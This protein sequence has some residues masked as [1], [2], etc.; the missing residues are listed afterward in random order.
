[1]KMKIK[2]L[3]KVIKN[4]AKEWV[5]DDP[6][7][8]SAIIAYYAI[9]SLPALLVLV[10]NIAGFFLEKDAISGEI[11]RQ[12][13]A[14]MGQDTG[15]QIQKIVA[16]A[17]KVKA[18]LL[19]G[20]IAIVVLISGATGV[21]VQLQ[22][23]LNQIWGVKQKASAGIM[24]T[25][26]NRVFSFGLILAIGFLLLVS[27][28]I[29]SVLA[30]VSHWLESALSDAVAYLI[31]VVDFVV[32]LGITS[33]LFALMFKYLPDVK[34][35]WKNVWIGGILTGFLFI[36]GKYGLSLYFGKA[37]PASV[38]GA[39]GSII[40]VLLWVSYSSMIVFFG[41]EFTQ[42]YAVATKA[43]IKVSENAEITDPHA[44]LQLSTPE[45]HK[46]K[47]R[48]RF[49]SI[50]SEKDLEAEI[51]RSELHLVVKKVQIKDKISSLTHIFRKKDRG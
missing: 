5:E 6:F 26:K 33:V 19:P 27:L 34:I 38:Y 29:S 37:N 24:V 7:R 48:P 49:A 41:A 45:A 3:G 1:M 21:F 12:I 15:E 47:S 31:Y 46:E 28:V 22:I 30:S 17:G 9:F 35:G 50:D 51:D 23:V 11:A 44:G 10:I 42:Q 16:N 4:T 18:G 14:V 25:I 40:L 8:Q 39:A 32:S 43:D 20:I 13:S 2:D 36:L